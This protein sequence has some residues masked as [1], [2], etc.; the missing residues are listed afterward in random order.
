[1]AQQAE[2][3]DQERLGFV[4]AGNLDDPNLQD[5]LYDRF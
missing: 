3:M 5:E 1:M 2:R 4:S